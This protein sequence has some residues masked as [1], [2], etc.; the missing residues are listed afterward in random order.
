[1]PSSTRFLRISSAASGMS[2]KFVGETMMPICTPPNLEF[3]LA[4]NFPAGS[5]AQAILPMSRRVYVILRPGVVD[6][7]ASDDHLAQL[8]AGQKEFQRLKTLKEFFQAPI[9]EDLL[10]LAAAPVGYQ[11]S[12]RILNA[13]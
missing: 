2:R 13:E 10:R 8:V 12:F 4:S 5:A 9:V 11:Q 6:S 1:M 3:G 7:S